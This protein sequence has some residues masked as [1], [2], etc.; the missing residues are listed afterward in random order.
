MSI[1]IVHR[2]KYKKPINTDYR[3]R[4]F[5]ARDVYPTQTQY[6]SRIATAKVKQEEETK[7]YEKKKRGYYEGKSPKHGQTSAKDLTI[8]PLPYIGLPRL[9]TIKSTIKTR[10]KR[11]VISIFQCN[12]VYLDM[13]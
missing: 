4:R 2:P 7:K 5:H 12:R 13:P 9:F 8:V 3:E 1:R 6:T 11:Q 10:N